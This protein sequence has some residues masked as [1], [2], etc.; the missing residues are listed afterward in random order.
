MATGTEQVDGTYTANI[1]KVHATAVDNI[2]SIN[3]ITWANNY[4]NPYNNI[5]TYSCMFDRASTSYLTRTLGGD[6]DSLRKAT[7]SAWVKRSTPSVS[8][9]RHMSFISIVLELRH[10]YQPEF[11]EIALDGIISLW[12]TIPLKLLQPTG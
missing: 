6:S 2:A 7:F 1:S 5:M 10:C 8:P 11:S 3:G 4:G 9:N 12:L